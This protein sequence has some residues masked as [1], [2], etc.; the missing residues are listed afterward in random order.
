MRAGNRR[1]TFELIVVDLARD[2]ATPL[3]RHL[4]FQQASWTADG[5]R[6]IGVGQ[7]GAGGRGIYAVAPE[8]GASAQLLFRSDAATSNVPSLAPDGKHMCY[9][10][11]D[12]SGDFSIYLRESTATDEGRPIVQEAPYEAACRISPDGRWFAYHSNE[13][14]VLNV[15]LRSF[16]DG[17]D[18]QQISIDGGQ[19]PAWRPDGRELYYLAPDGGFMAVAIDPASTL[20]VG[21]STRLFTAPVDPSFGTPGATLFDA[22]RDGQRFAMLVPTSDTPQPVTVI[23][24]WRELLTAQ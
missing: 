14:G 4:S 19:R 7:E 18:K 17:R 3:V 22:A 21:A 13:T 11:T 6:L 1:P 8:E 12:A 9:T 16:P 20:K 24:N 5:R 23:L 15:F 2:T 10:R